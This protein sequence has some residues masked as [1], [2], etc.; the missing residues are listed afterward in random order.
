MKILFIT[1]YAE[2]LGAN[3]C[4]VSIIRQF[5]DKY[6]CEPVVLL[7]KDGPLCDILKEEKIKYYIQPFYWWMMKSNCYDFM[8]YLDNLNKQRRN[9]F[10]IRNFAKSVLKD[11]HFDL[12]YSNSVTINVGV[13]LARYFHINHIWHFRED[14]SQFGF[15]VPPVTGFLS[16][17]HRSTKR[18]I[19]ISDF[20][21]KGYEKYIPS[22]KKVRIYD[23]VNLPLGISMRI[24]KKRESSCKP[25]NVCCV[26]AI[27]EQKN[28]KD[29]V[30]AVPILKSRGFD[31]KLHLIGPSDEDY[32]K[33][34]LSVIQKTSIS[35]DVVFYGQRRDVFEI[36]SQMDI[37][38]MPSKDEAFG[39][40]TIEYMLMGLPV[41][42]SNSGA[43]P[44]LVKEGRN[45]CLYELHNPESLACCLEK[46]MN[47]TEDCIGEIR[48]N[49]REDAMRFSEDANA[50]NLYNEFMVI[51]SMKY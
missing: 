13:I 43:N 51:Q 45:G 10:R 42:A 30:E 25:I 20:Q 47:E 27:S 36:L 22:R 14:L 18:F 11:E 8:H 28:Q 37:A 46:L 4:F 39:R 16:F 21:S 17:H 44:E 24:A 6:H 34:L 5:R 2:L 9:Y 29:V 26:G 31:V 23:G 40:V 12:V 50:D 35:D 1:H 7:P 19:T 33:E 15:V 32:E 38:V 48:K 41:V 49:N 3:L